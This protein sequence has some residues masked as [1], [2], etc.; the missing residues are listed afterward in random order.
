MFKVSVEDTLKEIRETKRFHLKEVAKKRLST[1][2][3]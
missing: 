3:C 2:R 1:I